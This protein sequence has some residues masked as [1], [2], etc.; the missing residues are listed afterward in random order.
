MAFQDFEL[1][2]DYK[3]KCK[4]CGAIIP[5]G[6]ESICSHWCSCTGKHFY[7][8]LLKTADTNNGNITMEEVEGLRELHL[9]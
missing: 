9:K 5:T 4:T 7:E 2:G 6:I 3:A 8:G 1:L